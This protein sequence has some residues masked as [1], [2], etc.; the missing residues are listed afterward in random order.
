MY[1]RL[2]VCVR[3]RVRACVKSQVGAFSGRCVVADV[4][5]QQGYRSTHKYSTQSNLNFSFLGDCLFN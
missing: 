4:M 2:Y 5:L 3:A 1:V